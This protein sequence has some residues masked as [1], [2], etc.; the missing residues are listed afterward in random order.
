MAFRLAGRKNDQN[1]T[2]MQLVLDTPSTIGIT[3]TVLGPAFLYLKSKGVAEY[4]AAMM[5]RY[6][7]MA[8]MV[9][10]GTIKV[11]LF[12]IGGWVQKIIPRLVCSEALQ[13][14]DWG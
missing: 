8:T 2:A 4:D 5:T 6:I 1:V 12:F 13:V 14:S 7:G 11:I 9:L 3:L 10:I